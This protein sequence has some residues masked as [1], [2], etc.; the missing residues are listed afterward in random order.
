MPIW[1]PCRITHLLPKATLCEALC[2]AGQ[3]EWTINPTP[4]LRLFK[5]V[6]YGD[7]YTHR[8]QTA[9]WPQPLAGA[10]PDPSTANPSTPASP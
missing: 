7:S 3:R 6:R 10:L 9:N 5:T 8:T 4:A 1:G 2:W